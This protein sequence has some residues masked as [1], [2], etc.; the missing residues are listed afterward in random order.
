M[1]RVG[2]WVNALNIFNRSK[3]LWAKS[4]RKWLFSF[5]YVHRNDY[6]S[7]FKAVGK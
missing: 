3:K 6:S 7:D 2:D 1:K 4:I 5:E